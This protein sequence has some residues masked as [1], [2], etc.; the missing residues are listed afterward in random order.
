MTRQTRVLIACHVVLDLTLGMAAFA[1][2]YFLRFE[3]AFL[4][5]GV[6][7]ADARDD[8]KTRLMTQGAERKTIRPTT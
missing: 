7:E 2:A 4:P 1:L 6:P 3:V 5:A 8:R